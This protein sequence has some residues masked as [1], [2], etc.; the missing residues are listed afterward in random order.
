MVRLLLANAGVAG[1]LAGLIIVAISVNVATILTIP[2]MTSRAGATIASLVLILVSS[3]A[4]LIPVQGPQLLGA[5]ILLFTAGTQIIHVKR[6]DERG[7]L[8]PR[9]SEG[10]PVGEL[11]APGIPSI[12][13]SRSEGRRTRSTPPW[14]VAP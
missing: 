9:Y 7:N 11:S 1:A 13:P 10:T 8:L 2:G 3:T 4:A 6:T 12:T 14:P 5:E